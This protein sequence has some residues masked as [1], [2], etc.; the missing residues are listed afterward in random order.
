MEQSKLWPLQGR[1]MQKNTCYVSWL[2][3]KKVSRLNKIVGYSQ[4]EWQVSKYVSP[5][6]TSYAGDAKK[7]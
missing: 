2:V 5:K 4:N 7:W 1:A 3:S 6:H